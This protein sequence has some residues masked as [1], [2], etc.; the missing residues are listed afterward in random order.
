MH[1]VIN[2]MHDLFTHANAD[3]DADVV[4]KTMLYRLCF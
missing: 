3:M 2:R 1:A 4:S